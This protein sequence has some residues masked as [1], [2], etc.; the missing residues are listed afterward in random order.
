M[1]MIRSATPADVPAILRFIRELADFEREPDAVKATEAGLHDALFGARPAA[2][3]VMAEV[4]EEVAG[5]AVFFHN[6][7]T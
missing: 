2:E 3:A 6:F 7:L 5:M 4:A 1:T